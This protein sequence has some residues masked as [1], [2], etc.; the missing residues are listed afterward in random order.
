MQFNGFSIDVT[1]R[2]TFND[3]DPVAGAYIG[4]PVT[5]TG[6]ACVEQAG[7]V[8]TASNRAGFNANGRIYYQDI[9]TTPYAGKVFTNGGMSFTEDGALLCDSSND[10]LY[11]LGGL[12]YTAAGY[13]AIDSLTPLPSFTLATEGGDLL[14]TE[15]GDYITT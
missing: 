15:S 10:I 3:T 11:Y 4:I 9:A 7:P 8:V 1:G 2:V 6:E 14:T 12:P 13:L 5:A